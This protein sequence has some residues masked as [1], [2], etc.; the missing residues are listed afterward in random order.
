MKRMLYIMG[1]E[2]NWIFQRP[3]ILADYLKEEYR[4]TVVCPKQM[5]HGRQQNNHKPEELIEL[6]QIPFQEKIAWIGRI[7]EYFHGKK[8]GNLYEYDIIWVGYPL[9]G[10]Y[11]PK[12]YQGIVVYDCMDNHEALFPDQRPSVLKRVVQEEKRLVERA[13]LIF[14]SSLKL[15]EKLGELCPKKE[16]IL[17]RNGCG[18]TEK[19]LPS[20]GIKKDSYRLGYIGTI[21]KWLDSELLAISSSNMP[22]IRYHLIGP[23]DGKHVKVNAGHVVYDG[24]IEHAKLGEVVEQMDCLIMPFVINDIILYVD[25]V[26]LYEYIAWGKCIIASWYPEIDRFQDFVYFYRNEAEYMELLGE[27]AEKGFPAKYEKGQQEA[28]LAENTW[29]A[30]EMLIQEE[31]T[32]KLG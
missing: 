21:S 2:W 27:L 8:L 15:K 14:V 17:V 25:P 19:I 26:K 9:F 31:L 6:T 3:Q 4:I 11:I 18:K 12:D 28:F 10:R 1:V 16:S 32:K 5:V 7:A 24:V 23:V 30:R 29:I 20:V 13:D 22:S